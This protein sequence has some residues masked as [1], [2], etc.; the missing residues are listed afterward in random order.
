VPLKI[1]SRIVGIGL[2]ALSDKRQALLQ[3]IFEKITHIADVVDASYVLLG[4][5]LNT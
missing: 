4:G 2:N 3:H 1:S 5:Q